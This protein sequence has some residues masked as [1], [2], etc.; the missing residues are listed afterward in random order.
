MR[1]AIQLQ[2]FDFSLEHVKETENLLPD[3][4]SRFSSECPLE[5]DVLE[6]RVFPPAL[7]MISPFDAL[8]QPLDMVKYAQA[9]DNGLQ[10]IITF[11]KTLQEQSAKLRDLE[12]DILE[13]YEYQD[14]LLLYKLGGQSKVLVPPAAIDD[15]LQY[16]HS[17]ELA[18]H[19]GIAETLIAVTEHFY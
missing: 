2:E 3:A 9:L 5:M 13:K 11:L 17:S 15:V 14:G 12:K 10:S 19:P 18:N 7:S 8:N 4:L 6:E 16:Y 1:W